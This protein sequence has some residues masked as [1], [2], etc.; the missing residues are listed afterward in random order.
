MIEDHES[1]EEDDEESDEKF[2]E[3]CDGE[4]D[5]ET[6]TRASIDIT[7]SRLIDVGENTTQNPQAYLTSWHEAQKTLGSAELVKFAALSYC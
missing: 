1:D 5:Q 6:T 4:S 7:P 2:G 3:E